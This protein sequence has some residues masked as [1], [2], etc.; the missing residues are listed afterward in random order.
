MPPHA[1]SRDALDRVRRALDVLAA[2]DTTTTVGD[3]AAA[4][5]EIGPLLWRELTLRSLWDSLPARDHAAVSWSVALGIQTSHACA[6][7]GKTQRVA[8][9]ITELISETAHWARACD[10]GAADRWPEAQ[11][12]RAHYGNA[13]QQLWQRYQALPHPWK[14][15]ILREMEPPP[16]PGRGRR[17]LPFA[18]ALA[19]AEKTPPPPTCT[20]DHPTDALVRSLSRR[21]SGWQVEIIRRI[22]AGAGPYR[23]N[24]A[25]DEA[26]RIVSHQGVRLIQR[27]SITE[28][29][30]G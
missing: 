25:A 14:I 29:A 6:T 24:A 8:R 12:R 16:G 27:P 23:T 4:A 17:R 28:M 22:V 18:T 5:R 13:A 2:W 7:Q 21:P 20:A 15:R 19:S 26:I 10:P 1:H 3:A 30:R 11:P 9:D